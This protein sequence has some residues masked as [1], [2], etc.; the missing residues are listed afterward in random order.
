MLGVIYL[1][2]CVLLYASQDQLLYHPVGRGVDT[3]HAVLASGGEQIVV[4]HNGRTGT[5]RAVL[6]LGGNA[7]DV[8][9]AVAQLSQ[10]FPGDHVAAMHY[11]GYGGSTGAPRE[12]ALVADATALYDQLAR[13]H[14]HITLVGRS[15][16]SGVAV[17]VAAARQPQR[18]VLVTPYDSIANVALQR[19]P[20]VPVHWLL[21]DHYDSARVAPSLRV[22]TTL[23]IAEH[24]EVIATSHSDRLA[25]H[26]S[27]G[28]AQVVRLPDV[29][30]NTVSMA[31]GYAAAL[32]G[33][34]ADQAQG[35]EAGAAAVRD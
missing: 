33:Q 20:I 25:Q 31:P 30:H 29:G 35:A 4:S 34:A 17:Q 9:A 13:T 6:Y 19:F 15:L 14:L 16:G 26:F 28:V 21:R 11:R 27:P 10:I 7:E 3:P 8:S 22:P 1:A 5:D 32:A 24:D 2:V 18:L 23:V 12:A